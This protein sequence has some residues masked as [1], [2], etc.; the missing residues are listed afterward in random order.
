MYCID[1]I[2]MNNPTVTVTNRYP[3]PDNIYLADAQ[4]GTLVFKWTPAIFNCSTLKYTIA[5][6]CGACPIITNKTTATCSFPQLS[7]N[8]RLCHFSV[9][10]SAC[11]LVGI[12]SST[13]AVTLKGTYIMRRHI[14]H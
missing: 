11:D 3:P 1:N 9:S 8:A 12:S 10:S 4:P 7:T 14:W 13:T 6:D 2:T 5:S